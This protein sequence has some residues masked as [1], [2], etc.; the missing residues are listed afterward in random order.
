MSAD[1]AESTAQRPDAAH[2]ADQPRSTFPGRTPKLALAAFCVF[3]L[4][5]ALALGLLAPAMF[6]L[7][8]GTAA[9][10]WTAACRIPI[11]EG[12]DLGMWRGVY[13]PM[14]SAFMYYIQ[15][16]NGQWV[17]VVPER[18]ASAE[19]PNVVA[20]LRRAGDDAP[21]YVRAAWL[22]WQRQKNPG[23]KA[24]R[25]LVEVIRS[26]R[27]VDL[28]K[29]DA[30]HDSDRYAS[31]LAVEATY[32]RLS[33]RVARYWANVV[34]EFFYFSGLGLFVLWP[35]LARK[36]ALAWA[37]HLP[38]A[39]LLIVLPY[40]FGYCRTVPVDCGYPTGGVLY[41][42]L[43]VRFHLIPFWQ[44]LDRLAAGSP[45]R[46]EAGLLPQLLEP[47][48][49]PF[50]PPLTW[51]WSYLSLADAVILGVSVGALALGIS[52]LCVWAAIRSRQRPGT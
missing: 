5:I 51:A 39:P 8:R 46:T 25:R 18:V 6:P 45:D 37:F 44:A 23:D 52:G 19:L 10:F 4:G 30:E 11:S 21:P 24:A 42:W 32:L 28:L 13:P 50:V 15:G 9:A 31:S 2:A 34:F 14:E 41:P 49:Q 35:W 47:L 43:A 29:E 38:V 27:L 36:G 40:W 22:T 48:T 33:R 3:L 26:A 7:S 1:P 17:Y 16:Y 12:L 20:A